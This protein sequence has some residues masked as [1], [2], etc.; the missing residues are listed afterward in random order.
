MCHY[1]RMA[2]DRVRELKAILDRVAEQAE[3]D[4]DY[5]PDE[6]KSLR[7]EA[8][9]AFVA[10][11]ASLLEEATTALWGYY[12]ATIDEFSPEQRREYGLLPRS[13]TRRTSRERVQLP[14]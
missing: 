8:I 9:S 6:D 7:A 14:A 3:L 13:P 10:G 2:S 5:D 4:K 12:R 11:G 1:A